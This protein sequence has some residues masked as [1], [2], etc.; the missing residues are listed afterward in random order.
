MIEIIT[1]IMNSE[2]CS[3]PVSDIFVLFSLVFSIRIYLNFIMKLIRG[4]DMFE[5]DSHCLSE[6]EHER[7]DF[8]GCNYSPDSIGFF[9]NRKGSAD[10]ETD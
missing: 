7:T 1:E 3:V 4:V 8:I 9:E 2:I 5:N 6:T 10:N